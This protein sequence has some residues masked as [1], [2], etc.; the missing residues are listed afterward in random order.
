MFCLGLS[1]FDDVKDEE[2]DEFIFI[3]LLY[4]FFFYNEALFWSSYVMLHATSASDV[5]ISF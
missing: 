5:N 1:P 2:N 4:T 3:L